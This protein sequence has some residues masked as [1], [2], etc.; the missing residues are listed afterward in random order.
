MDSVPA[1]AA[2]SEIVSFAKKIG[3]GANA[4]FI[5]AVLKSA[6]DYVLPVPG[7]PVEALAFKV[8]VPTWIVQ[9]LVGRFGIKETEA[10]L[11]Y[12][13]ARPN[14][15]INERLITECEALNRLTKSGAAPERSPLG[16]FRI[17][18]NDTVK[19]MFAKGLIT[20]QSPS[21]VYVAGLC[22]DV[23][24]RRVLDL[25]SAPGGKAIAIAEKTGAEVLAC[26]VHPH[27]TELIKKYAERMKTQGI[28]TKVMDG[29]VLNEDL[30][31]AFDLVLVDAPCSGI[32][33]IAGKPEMALSRR[34]VD[35]D[36][37]VGVQKKLI[38]TAANYVKKG[39]YLT[40]STCTLFFEEN[41]GVAEWF[42]KAHPDFVVDMPGGEKMGRTI[43]PHVEKADGFF[44]V[45]MKRV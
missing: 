29:T 11:S 9:K 23:R 13:E 3:K 31:G 38:S 1:Y 41:E 16:G 44:A 30:V 21:S 34:P 45:R 22:A 33:V 20:Y 4:G 2:T 32:G 42:L 8:S 10:I 17:T 15:R 39:G 28:S 37:L 5:N 12:R 36:T 19:K 14:I 26:D 7:D 18:L 35:V 25:C 6:V 24:P 40:Y 43:L 27:R